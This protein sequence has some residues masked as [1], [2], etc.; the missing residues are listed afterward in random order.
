MYEVTE[1]VAP[2]SFTE[3]SLHTSFCEDLDPFP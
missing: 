3:C 2:E 1:K